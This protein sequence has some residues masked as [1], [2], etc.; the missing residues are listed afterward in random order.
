MSL[1]L[2]TPRARVVTLSLAAGRSLRH[3]DKEQET[4]SQLVI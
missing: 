3:C 4:L 1:A 2:A